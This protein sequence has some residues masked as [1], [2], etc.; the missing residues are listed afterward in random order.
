MDA[1]AIIFIYIMLWYW[2]GI[3]SFKLSVKINLYECLGDIKFIKSLI[4][5][6]IP[7][8]SDEELESAVTAINHYY[9]GTLK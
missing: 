8:I 3:R 7:N 1:S 2:T 9:G 4:K 6:H 5:K